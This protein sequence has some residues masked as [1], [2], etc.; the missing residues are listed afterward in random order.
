MTGSKGGLGVGV[1]S[2]G[3]YSLGSVTLSALPLRGT[4][5]PYGKQ[6]VLRSLELPLVQHERSGQVADLGGNSRGSAV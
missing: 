1:G 4:G 2:L 5:S 6:F 3:R